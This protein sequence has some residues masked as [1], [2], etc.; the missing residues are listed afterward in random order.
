MKTLVIKATMI[1][2]NI[3]YVFGQFYFGSVVNH[4]GFEMK[5]LLFF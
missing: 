3:L 5:Q 4:I 1:I 2:I